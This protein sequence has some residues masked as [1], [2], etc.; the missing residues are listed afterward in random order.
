[1]FVAASIPNFPL[2]TFITPSPITTTYASSSV[3]IPSSSNVPISISAGT[4]QTVNQA[5]GNPTDPI[6]SFVYLVWTDL[7]GDSGCDS[8]VNSPVT[9]PDCKTRI[10]F[11]RGTSKYYQ[12]DDASGTWVFD[13]TWEA[14]VKIND[15]PSKNDQFDPR[16]AVDETNG[17]L[18]V[19]Y[20]DTVGDDT[21]TSSNVF[22][23]ISEDNGM[24][25][26]D[27][28][29][30][31]TSAP[32]NEVTSDSWWQY[33][34]YIGLATYAGTCIA[35]WTDR[36]KSSQGQYLPEQIWGRLY[37]FPIVDYACKTGDPILTSAMIQFF[38]PDDVF[39][40][41]DDKDWDTHVRVDVCTI[42]NEIVAYLD[43]NLGGKQDLK[44]Q[45]SYRLQVNGP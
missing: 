22:L 10:W 37:R 43:S 34:D 6:S 2:G 33:G 16:L 5:A 15:Q 25:W 20:Y 35:A 8:D 24:N 3:N 40:A 42:R 26:S 1:M 13:I 28:I 27:A 30:P 36:R 21:R 11:A 38:T 18:V 32:T 45:S 31:V 17:R 9:S 19:V 4:Y 39:G 44:V 14:P 29:T 7:S 23:Q 12:L 41:E